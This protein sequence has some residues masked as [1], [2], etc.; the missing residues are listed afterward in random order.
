MAPLLRPDP[1]LLDIYPLPPPF[2]FAV[3]TYTLCAPF[4]FYL[5][6]MAI[7]PYLQWWL[8]GARRGWRVRFCGFVI[9]H[10]LSACSRLRVCPSAARCRPR[11]VGPPPP[12]L[13]VTPPAPARRTLHSRL[14]APPPAIQAHAAAA[15]RETAPAPYE[16]RARA[17]GPAACSCLA[18]SWPLRM[19]VPPPRARTPIFGTRTLRARRAR[20]IHTPRSRTA[21]AR[22]RRR[23]MRSG[24]AGVTSPA[25]VDGTRA[26]AHGRK[27]IAASMVP[28]SAASPAARDLVRRRP[29]VILP[30]LQ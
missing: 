28:G 10:L 20:P 27:Y 29:A 1:L 5:F 9:I 17:R 19:L 24:R 8:C 2:R 30:P 22:A 3:H 18:G 11:T 4:T 21:G 6:R 16:G 23:S 25:D 15:R 12:R 7:R 14:R 13:H 26:R